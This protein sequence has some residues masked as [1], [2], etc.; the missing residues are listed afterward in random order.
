MDF[1]YIIGD[2]RITLSVIY[3]TIGDNVITLSAAITLSVI[4]TLSVVTANPGS[5]AKWP[6]EWREIQLQQT[7]NNM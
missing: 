4:I 7:V 5:P 2:C 3:Y 6:L 1:Y